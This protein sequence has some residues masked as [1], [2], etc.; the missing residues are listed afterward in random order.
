MAAMENYKLFLI[1]LFSAAVLGVV[2]IIFV[3]RWVLH[4]KEGLAWDGGSAEFNWHPVLIVCGFIVL[5]GL[6]IIVYR[7]PW[8]WQYSKLTMKFIHA[9][10]NL[11]A[12]I[13]AVVSMVAVFDYHNAAKIPNM[14][15]LHSWLGL[16]AVILYGVQ[17]VLGFGMYLIPVTPVSWRAAFMPVHVYSG[18]LLFASIIA[19]ALMGITEKLIFALT[20][21][22]YKDSPPEAIF[23]NVLGFLLVV[24]GALI[25]WIAT[26]QSWKRPSE[27]ILHSLHS[28]RAGE[29]STKVGPAM[30]QL[31]EENDAE[32]TGELRRRSNH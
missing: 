8:S 28:D 24:F 12:F 15:S 1:T 3:L 32:A 27:Q 14:Y 23:V 21:P 9:G 26:R 22:K 6:A 11:V 25:L 4:F 18:L 13:F 20:N 17:L 31:S 29:E 2:S 5:Q 16:T 19:V 10:L 30:S 7:L